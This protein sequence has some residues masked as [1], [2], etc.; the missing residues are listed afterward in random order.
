MIIFF[1]HDRTR[2]SGVQAEPVELRL[3]RYRFRA[4]QSNRDRT[5][6]PVPRPG[7][8]EP[9]ARADDRHRAPTSLRLDIFNIDRIRPSSATV[10]LVELGRADTESVLD[11]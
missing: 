11:A 4:R 7:P 10:E 9:D 1:F 6:V 3:S 8:D 2:P 5:T